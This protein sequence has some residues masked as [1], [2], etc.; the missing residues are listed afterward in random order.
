MDKIELITKIIDENR[1]VNKREKDPDSCPCYNGTKCHNHAS[2]YEMICL[3]CVCPEYRK[4]LV[5]GGCKIHNPNGKWFYHRDLPEGKIW[6]C[7]DC[8]LPHTEEYVRNYLE[9]LSTERLNEIREC[10][11]INDFWKF[12]ERC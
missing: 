5:E 7:S 11:T 8:E 12:F 4:D 3:L 6:D 9:K 1:L 10:K 2:D